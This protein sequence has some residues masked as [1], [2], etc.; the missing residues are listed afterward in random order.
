[1]PPVAA[2]ALADAL[3]LAPGSWEAGGADAGVPPPHAAMTMLT[4]D[5]DS[6]MTDARWMNWRRVILPW[7][8]C[9]T[10]S[11]SSGVADRRTRSSRE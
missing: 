4:A 7:A 9:S 2:D 10:R 8:K 1:V 5:I 6:P 3:G 11:S